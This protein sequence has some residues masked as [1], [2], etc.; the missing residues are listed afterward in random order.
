VTFAVPGKYWISIRDTESGAD[1]YW[2][3]GTPNGDNTVVSRPSNTGNWVSGSGFSDTDAQAVQ[4][5]GEFTSLDGDSD[6]IN[7][8]DDNC[9]AISNLDQ[10]NNDGDTQGNACDLDDDNDGDPDLTDCAP[11]NA[12]IGHGATEIC[13][14]VD[15]NCN[16]QIDEGFPDADSDGTANCSDTDDDNDGVPDV[17]DCDPLN[18]KNDEWLICHK[19]NTLCIAKSAV[20]AH[21][22]HGD[23]LGTCSAVSIILRNPAAE[24][25]ALPDKFT[26]AGY[27]N[28]FTKA[29]T[30]RYTVPVDARVTIKVFDQMGR[31][32]ST[33][34]NGQKAAGSYSVE[35]NTAK[36]RTG[37]YYTRMIAT[38]N[39]KEFIQTQKLIKAE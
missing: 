32:V 35:Y 19:G 25:L 18:M 24:S 6:G 9:P 20:Q 10:A 11:L 21:L 33:V 3:S 23:Y 17:Y 2:E 37:G 8:G 36:L 38:A 27:P 4:I 29:T 5:E 30:I 34:F 31:E 7:D 12:A 15:N 13:D 28:P 1:F 26:L 14:G 22:R 39:G 16:G